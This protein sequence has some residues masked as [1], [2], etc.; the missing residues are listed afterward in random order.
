[1][2][3]D[4]K[5]LFAGIP[6]NAKICIWGAA[7]AGRSI[8]E[9]LAKYRQD[10]TVCAFIDSVKQG[11]IDGVKIYK[12]ENMPEIKNNFDYMIISTRSDCTVIDAMLFYY[13]IKNYVRISP[14]LLKKYQFIPSK[15]SEILNFW[16]S[17]KD[18]Q[19]YKDL[20]E[21]RITGNTDKL[22]EFVQKEHNITPDWKRT[23]KHYTSYINYDAIE[24][25]LEGGMFNGLNTIVFKKLFK[26]LKKIYAFELIYDK[27]KNK[28]IAH[29]IDSLKELEIIP[30]ALWDR[31]EKLVFTENVAAP[32]SSGINP[33]LN[34]NGSEQN[35]TVDAISIDEYVSE[36]NIEKVD[37]IKMD[38]EG[39][40]MKALKGAEQTLIKHRP[41][42]AISIYHSNNDMQDIPIYL[43]NILKNYIFKIGQY[44]PDNDE[45][46]LYAIPEELNVK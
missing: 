29:I 7:N 2:P 22:K 3:D 43:H 10:T 38:I 6:E 17:E 28:S 36:N 14:Y 44:S 46:I 5:N 37:F 40:E 20:I 12:P 26:N 4:I 9:E 32:Y 27:V 24:V 45:T 33:P 18:K 1:M 42:L 41:Q 8:K 39:A 16:D 35:F 21:A 30:L 19:L 13:D 34:K 15:I 31:K 11:E 25:V 23:I